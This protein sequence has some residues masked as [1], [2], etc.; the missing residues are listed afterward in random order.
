MA[1]EAGGDSELVA[2]VVPA[3]GAG[4][5]VAALSGLRGHVQRA[6]ARVH[7]ARG[8]RGSRGLPLTPNGKLDRRALPAPER[9]GEGRYCGPR[10]PEEQLLC[11][12]YAEVLGL[13]RVGIDDNFFAL[14]G[15]SLLATRLV[16]RVRAVLGVELA[17]RALFEAPRVAGAGGAAG[18][19]DGV[20]A[21]PLVWRR[22]G[23]GGSRCPMRSSGCG[24]CT[25]WKGERDLQPPGGAAAGGGGGCGGAGGG[26]GRGGGAA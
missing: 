4:R 14:G 12:L 20:A 10:T 7:G 6:A 9:R 8:L 25:G 11:E 23:R 1:R 13:E 15:H 3:H 21:R 24:F 16:S 17:L 18:G 22:G 2:Y 5:D 19:E 26:A